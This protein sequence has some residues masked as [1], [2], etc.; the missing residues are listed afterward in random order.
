MAKWQA[1]DRRIEKFK[2]IILDRQNICLIAELNEKV[3]GYLLGGK[4]KE[5]ANIPFQYE[6][7]G[8]YVDPEFQRNGAGRLLLQHFQ[9]KIKQA[10]FFLHAMK[11]NEKAMTFY[12][13][14]GGKRAPEYDINKTWGDVICR[15]EAFVFN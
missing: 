7:Y 8:L 1:T 2:A 14:V 11:G 3:I 10:L 9:Q 4:N 6:V 15:I 12:T 5:N 13:K